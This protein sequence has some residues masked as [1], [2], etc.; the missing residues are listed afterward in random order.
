[1]LKELP[2]MVKGLRNIATVLFLIGIGF[3]TSLVLPA[4]AV[5][6]DFPDVA[7]AAGWDNL[8]PATAGTENWPWWRGPALDNHAPA[9][10]PPLNWS[11]QK[12]VRW[13]LQLPGGG[14]A[15]PCIRG[16]R[17]FLPAGDPELKVVWMLCFDR[18]T[19]RKLW[20]T[21]VYRGPLAKIHNDNSLAS[22][23]PACDGERVYFPYQTADTIS[24]AALDLDGKVVWNKPVAPYKSIQGYS[25]SPALYHSAVIIAVDGSVGNRLTAFHRQ[26][27]EV[28]WCATMRKVVEN[29]ASPLVARVAGRDQVLLAGGLTTRSYDPNNGKLLWECNGPADFCVATVAFDQ[30]TVYATGGYP[31]NAL[32][33]IRADGAGDVTA[34]HVRW[35]GDS[36]AGYV[37]S[38]MLNGGLLYA[39]NDSGLMRCYDA[40]TGQVVWRTSSRPSSTPPRSWPATGFTFSTARARAT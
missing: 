31:K 12:N 33:A 23:T 39:V 26:T 25:A 27:G 2:S 17:I 1:M 6:E 13:R 15:T 22:A 21:E 40:A 29:Y 32:L 18:A 19:G 14:H 34:S 7:P 35:K 4:A 11:E 10:N 28:V 8:P 9:R 37:P 24:L 36:K 16:D 38:P 3:A 20:Q 30:D 5:A